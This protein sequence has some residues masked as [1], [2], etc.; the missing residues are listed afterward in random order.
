MINV[1]ELAKPPIRELPAL[2]DDQAQKYLRE[3]I[4][5]LVGRI[6]APIR[7]YPFDQRERDDLFVISGEGPIA[8]IKSRWG[9]NLGKVEPEHGQKLTSEVMGEFGFDPEIKSKETKVH[10]LKSGVSTEVLTYPSQTIKGLVFERLVKSYT[11][12]NKVF[13]I[14][15]SIRDAAPKLGIN[16][17]N[18]VPL[19]T[20]VGM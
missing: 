9:G 14:W 18:K 16:I 12:D 20:V 1:T 4:V 8:F 17:R 15:W 13:E 19:D 7:L 11:K 10:N 5:P 2:T 3:S 6:Q